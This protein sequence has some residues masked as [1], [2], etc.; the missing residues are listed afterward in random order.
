MDWKA[1]ITADPEILCGKPVIRGTRL[2][3]EFILGLLGQNWTEADIK[4]NYPTVS[5][6][7]ISAC[8]LYAAESLQTERVYPLPQAKAI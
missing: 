2:S 7:D 8:L 5:H 3:V 4:D 1:R 6:D